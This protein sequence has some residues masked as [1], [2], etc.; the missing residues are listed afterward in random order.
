MQNFV[1]SVLPSGKKSKCPFMN[2]TDLCEED[3][4]GD[5]ADKKTSFTNNILSF[6][7]SAQKFCELSIFKKGSPSSHSV[8]FAET[9]AVRQN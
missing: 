8:Y 7:P 5:L 4:S 2:V 3:D 6:V 1:L 9:S